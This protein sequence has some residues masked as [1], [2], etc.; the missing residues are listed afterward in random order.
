MTSEEATKKALFWRL[1]I[2]IPMGTLI[3]YV[4][5][6]EVWRSISLMIF[7]NIFFTILH[8]LYE[9]LWPTIWEY[10]PRRKQ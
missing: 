1:F 8:I 5:I 10:I 6:G 3:T 2:A 4:W 9:K 7:M